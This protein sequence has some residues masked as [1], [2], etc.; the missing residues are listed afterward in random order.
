MAIRACC[1]D[2][3]E[4]AAANAAILRNEVGSSSLNEVADWGG[5]LR[6]EH[7]AKSPGEDGA[8]L[9]KYDWPPTHSTQPIPRRRRPVAGEILE[10]GLINMEVDVSRP[11]IVHFQISSVDPEIE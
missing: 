3:L 6:F 11:N 4:T 9:E 1:D 5:A 2:W 10:L 8:R 7:A